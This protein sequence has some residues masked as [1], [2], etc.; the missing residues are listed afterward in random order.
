MEELE[1]G[2]HAAVEM[3]MDVGR[4]KI[5]ELGKTDSKIEYMVV[6]NHSGFVYPKVGFFCAL[7]RD[8]PMMMH[9]RALS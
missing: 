7:L 3:S 5:E 8:H 4:S 2:H 1:R 6:N 9:D